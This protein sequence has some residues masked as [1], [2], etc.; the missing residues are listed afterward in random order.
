MDDKMKWN[1]CWRDLGVTI[2][3]EF[4]TSS[5]NLNDQQWEKVFQMVGW[6]SD[7]AG[8]YSDLT[9]LMGGWIDGSAIHS[10]QRQE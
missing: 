8:W 3:A 4:T 2:C 5:Y 7:D 6:L 10:E 9:G 1:C